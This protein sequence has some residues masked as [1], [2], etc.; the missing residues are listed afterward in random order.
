MREK[1][2][3]KVRERRGEEIEI[4]RKRAPI[5]PE[6]TFNHFLW[7]MQRSCSWI[8]A[9]AYLEGDKEETIRKI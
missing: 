3:E 1:Q 4:K 6:Y 9:L 5:S 8:H 2:K 7:F